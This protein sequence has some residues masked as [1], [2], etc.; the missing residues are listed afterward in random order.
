MPPKISSAEWEVMTVV[1]AKAPLTATE[2]FEALPP[3][4][5]WKQKTVNTFLSRLVDKGVVAV[6]KRERAHVYTARVPRENCVQAES[7]S[8]LQRVFNGATGDLVL[9]FAARADLSGDEIRE[10][11][12]LL[13]AKKGRK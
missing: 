8:F 5:G 11:E 3:G 9:H 7:E 10:L 1:W 12:Q 6:D 2:V 13:K 4:H